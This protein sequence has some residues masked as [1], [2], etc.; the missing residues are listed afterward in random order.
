[1]SSYDILPPNE[2][3]RGMSYGE[4]AAEWW[5][6][7][8]GSKNPDYS[9]GEPVLFLRGAYEYYVEGGNRNPRSTHNDR[10]GDR[11]IEISE[12][13][14]IF[15]PVIGA[16]F[17]EED[18]DP[19]DG[20]KKITTEAE[21]RYFAR[22]DIDEGGEMR[23]TIQIGTRAPKTKIVKDL[24]D[25][26]AES[27]L[28]K[29]TVSD[30]CTLKDKLE[31]EQ[32]AG[33]FDAVTDGYWILIRSLPPSEVPYQIHFEAEGRGRYFY[34]GTYDIKVESKQTSKQTSRVE[35]KSD[36]P[37]TGNSLRPK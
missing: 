6:W 4:W 33:T 37:I 36:S 7:L 25:Y 1:M 11:K 15:F 13:T 14:A 29:L 22:R 24:K 26:R 27:P 21:M 28:F 18:P 30:Q 34:S 8:L 23:A 16:E 9:K 10:T 19:D 2:N 12:G 20:G 31:V 17:N 3:F 35:D 32:K 5:K